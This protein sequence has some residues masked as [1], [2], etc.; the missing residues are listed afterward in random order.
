MTRCLV[1]G[2]TG[3]LGS[4]LVQA[5]VDAGHEVGAL[6]RA[7]RSADPLPSSVTVHAGDATQAHSVRD[8]L[9]DVEVAY[10][11]V[12]SMGRDDFADVDRRAATILAA[13]AAAAGV[14]QVVYVGG[15]RPAAAGD[16]SEHLASRAEVGDILVNGRVP[17]LVLQASMIIGHGSTSFDLLRT[18]TS[19]SPWVP[20]PRWMLNTSRPVAAAD[21]V[22]HLL[23]AADLEP[24]VRGVFDVSGPETLS[25]LSLVQRYARVT[26]LRVRLPVPAPLWSHRLAATLVGL[27]TPIPSSVAGPLFESLDHDLEPTGSDITDALP[28]PPGG[29]TTVDNAI[30]DACQP[31]DPP[32]AAGTPFVDEVVV[33]SDA[34]PDRVWRTITGLGGANGWHTIPLVWTF[35]GALDHLVGGVG[36]YRGRAPE[37]SDGDVV[38]SWTVLHRDDSARRLVLRADMRMPGDTTLE[39]SVEQ[40]EGRTRYRQKITF[41]PDGQAGRLYWQAQKPLHDLVFTTMAHGIARSSSSGG[42]RAVAEALRDAAN[43]VTSR[44][45]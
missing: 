6:V 18:S 26:G 20:V 43:H 15:P 30:R 12:H 22:H 24:P 16:V 39:M 41:T 3:Y 28:A 5:L 25:Y 36:L 2:A 17:A 1:M 21:V 27:V 42:P 7:P 4:L 34:G 32:T 45:G 35:R 9:A 11:L 23:T 33:A 10:F 37:I 38:D 31:A 8:A 40:H 29:P 14:R 19:L 44:L 13:E